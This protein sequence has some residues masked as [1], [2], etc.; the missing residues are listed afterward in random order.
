MPADRWILRGGECPGGRP[1]K[2]CHAAPSQSRICPYRARDR[3]KTRHYDN[4]TLQRV[5]SNHPYH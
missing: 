1:Y 2:A 3:E 5:S 4:V